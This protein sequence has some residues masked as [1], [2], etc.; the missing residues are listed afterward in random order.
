M[1]VLSIISAA[2]ALFTLASANCDFKG[3]SVPIGLKYCDILSN[4]PRTHVAAAALYSEAGS[5]A[6]VEAQEDDVRD[7]ALSAERK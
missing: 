3:K 4:A 5:G 6:S 7:I 2:A 1:Q